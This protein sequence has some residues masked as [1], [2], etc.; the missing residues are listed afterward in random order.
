MERPIVVSVACGAEMKLG[1]HSYLITRWGP[2][3]T[4]N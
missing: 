2:V 3:G 1:E 4:W